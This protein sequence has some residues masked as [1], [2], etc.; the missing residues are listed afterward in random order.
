M[1]E[2][3]RCLAGDRVAEN[4]SFSQYVHVECPRC[5][6]PFT[7]EIYVLVDTAERPDLVQL[8][9]DMILHCPVCP[10]CNL[11][12]DV[13]MPLLVYR[14]DQRV[15]VIFAPVKGSST[16]QRDEQAQMLFSTLHQRL[17]GK[18]RDDLKR[19]VYVTDLAGLA[20]V[21]D[22][23]L[24]LVRGGR[25]E[26]LRLAMEQYLSCDTWEESLAVVEGHD[27]LLGKEALAA[28]RSSIKAAG[29]A[30]DVDAI[31]MFTEHLD[32]LLDC[33]RQGVRNAFA[34][35][36]NGSGRTVKPNLVAVF[37]G[38]TRSSDPP[39]QVVTLACAG[40]DRIRRQDNEETWARMQWTL[41]DALLDLALSGHSSETDDAAWHFRAALEFFSADRSLEDWG[42]LSWKLHAAW[43][44]T[45]S[46]PSPQQLMLAVMCRA[47]ERD[48][49]PAV[50]QGAW[51]RAWSDICGNADLPTVNDA[52]A[53]LVR[54]GM[55]RPTDDSS[56]YD[57]PGWVVTSVEA[58]VNPYHAKII[59]SALADYWAGEVPSLED[60]GRDERTR[61]KAVAALLSAA[62]YLT[63]ARQWGDLSTCLNLLLSLDR[64]P[65]MTQEVLGYWRV[66]ADATG[67]HEDLAEL[68]RVLTGA[69]PSE[70]E[71][72]LRSA[73]DSANAAG[74]LLQEFQTGFDLA[75]LL[76]TQGRAREAFAINDGLPVLGDQ[77]RA[78]QW[79]MLAVEI[80]RLMIMHDLGE[81]VVDRVED[82][83]RRL[84]ELQAVDQPVDDG[85]PIIPHAAREVL[86]HLGVRA[87][88]H[89]GRWGRAL[90]FSDDLLKG[91]QQRGATAYEIAEAQHNRYLPLFG[92]GDL[93]AAEMIMLYCREV[94]EI[95]GHPGD[96]AKT[97]GAL[98]EIA[99]ARGHRREAIDFQKETLRH[100]YRRPDLSTLAPAHKHFARYLDDDD[101]EARLA[102]SLLAAITYRFCGEEDRYRS[103]LN[104][105]ANR[106]PAPELMAAATPEWLA[107]VTGRVDG[108]D[109][110]ILERETGVDWATVTTGLA[111]TLAILRDAE[112][113]DAAWNDTLRRRWEPAVAAMVAAVSGDPRAAA[114]LSEHL[115][116]RELAPDWSR[117]VDALRRI[118]G[119]ERDAGALIAGLHPVDAAVV[120]STLDALAGRYQPRATVAE[121]EAVTR[122]ARQ[123]H[124][125]FLE[126][127]IAAAR[128]DLLARD[129][130]NEWAETL[131]RE[132]GQYELTT[133]VLA[134]V[135]GAREPDPRFQELTPAQSR[136]IREIA[137]AIDSD[138][139]ETTTDY[140]ASN[141]LYVT[142][143]D[144]IGPSNDDI[145]AI[146]TGGSDLGQ[147]A[148]ATERGIRRR[149]EAGDSS[150]P[151][152]ILKLALPELLS[153]YEFSHALPLA[154]LLVLINTTDPSTAI[155]ADL[156]TLVCLAGIEV[157]KRIAPGGLMGTVGSA[158]PNRTPA[159]FGSLPSAQA[160]RQ[161]RRWVAAAR[162]LHPLVQSDI[163]EL[164]L[165]VAEATTSR[166][167][168]DIEDAIGKLQDVI[169]MTSGEGPDG[170]GT[171][172]SAVYL[173]AEAYMN[174]G[175]LQAALQSCNQLVKAR[176]DSSPR[177]IAE[178]LFLRATVLNMLGRTRQALADLN[179]A[180]ALLGPGDDVD[181]ALALGPVYEKLG[182]LYESL[183]QLPAAAEAF[184]QGLRIA[185]R[186]GHKVGEAAMLFGLGSLFGKLS[187][188]YLK[189][190]ART[191]L[192]DT[193]KV[194][195]RIDPELMHL[196]T[197]EGTHSIAETLLRRAADRFR[198]A[199]SE[200]GWAR[201]ING[202]S[203]LLPDDQSDEAAALLNEALH[204]LEGDRLTQAITLANLSGRLRT[205]GR[206]AEADDALRQSLGIARTAGYF[207]S[208]VG[209]ATSLARHA[210]ARGD[211]SAA[212]ASFRD[213]VA[214]IESVRPHRP[215]EDLSRIS[216][217]Q[218]HARAYTGLVDCLL[219]R[220]ADDEAFNIVQQA[221]SRAL[222]EL[223]G[224]SDLQPS[225][226]AEGRFAELLAAEAEHLTTAR[227]IR[228]NPAAAN[229]A[230]DALSML[231]DEMATYDPEYV[232]IR[233]GTPATVGS[234][235]DWLARQERPVLLA[236]YFTGTSGLTIF[237]LRPEWES[238]R[239]YN[240]N[241]TEADIRRGYLDFRRQVIQYRN[242]AGAGWTAMSG[243]ITEPLLPFL[244]PA[245]LVIL[246]PH[247]ILHA[248]PL[249]AL[250]VGGVPLASRHPVTYTPSCGLFQLCQSPGKGTGQLNSC[251]A[252]G[253]TYHAEA[254]AV[255][256]LFGTTPVPAGEVSAETIAALAA[257]RD[258]AH[259]SC[260]AYFSPSDPLGS[261]LYLKPG[262]PSDQQD[263]ADLL[264]A[265]QL[266]DM[267][268]QNEL[269]TV[270]A[271][272]TGVQRALDGDELV[273]L[274]RALLHAG[275][276]S[277]IA[278]LWPVDADTTRDFMVQFY[279]H[280]LSA[281]SGNGT[282]D[283]ADALR[284]AQLDLM[285]SRGS[286]ASYYWAPFV[287][288]GD[289]S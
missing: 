1:P 222:L 103:L 265:R 278:S 148:A 53:T 13:G 119:G 69:N 23:D 211:L 166:A 52:V 108:V 227:R 184:A 185:R 77:A 101:N 212:E 11:V 210:F 206:D 161:A 7:P 178:I 214:M 151:M 267:R 251:A 277:V 170:A 287:L 189:P 288:I 282:I 36:C 219:A 41:G 42:E 268:L 139:P 197:R 174:R 26:S 270:S 242:S 229:Q 63:R 45:H 131:N 180:R 8:I 130:L 3:V 71:R 39:Q 97:Y 104:E 58:G 111:A 91:M 55:I 284:K 96:L 224:T 245:D 239:V 116:V 196:P 40:L 257:D 86:L 144:P 230:H 49:V 126:M 217:A 181:T 15:P 289:W 203:N 75:G 215:A 188:G 281:Y 54:D 207:E 182:S 125:K 6:K 225:P 5:K 84:E 17:G 186:T 261:G 237:L 154:E 143:S 173:L 107:A 124:Q 30:G 60:A 192:N 81:D 24:D 264:T 68:E 70:S 2:E 72:R 110:S 279:A 258:V 157:A 61:A 246:V 235:R 168:G 82:L 138:A 273:G 113:S 73:R 199:N 205:L 67:S 51:R 149:L 283:K 19:H 32:V 266:M 137:D 48:R 127:A 155:P 115:N 92:L 187:T 263:P 46:S 156:A 128:G 21:V 56:P 172:G 213:A 123:R 134:V 285:E 59:D 271:C 255:A 160:V 247:G 66:I 28:L 145:R 208:A 204:A 129:H 29:A 274:A 147:A 64:S 22:L 9:K 99:W 136:L 249:H 90:A 177:D 183:G 88:N 223:L 253:I 175:D 44:I 233:R 256:A 117:L 201:A 176:S 89:R 10:F 80:Q 244:Q 254:E 262:D 140:A 169:A 171:H 200:D 121:L 165:T 112:A 146:F 158:V 47:S 243:R 269:V 114:A 275:A 85:E 27:V 16:E 33:G 83:Q 4:V 122:D 109:L 191:E 18:W 12:L 78:G 260:H 135:D 74:D 98:G 163:R 241:L 162:A 150:V 190:I 216:F 220:G 159:P 14:P 152:L 79:S 62:P 179:D 118:L 57:V 38:L 164:R 93:D 226:P 65:A 142:L 102:H 167:A 221:K 238:V 280:L 250:Q 286:R 95:H 106:H 132:D 87:A 141:E 133:A 209:S 198:A 231:Y 50:V 35:K 272:E 43:S 252:F 276:P 31:A 153:R 259:F 20:S 120:T 100:I 37:G 248:L 228:E 195:Y 105:I 202:L 232:A 34:A 194:L 25:D 76:L 240:S 218:R 193:I 94:F 236:E 234:V